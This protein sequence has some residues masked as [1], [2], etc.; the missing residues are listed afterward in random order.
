MK[1]KPNKRARRGKQ[2]TKSLEGAID[3]GATAHYIHERWRM[4]TGNPPET[5]TF[6]STNPLKRGIFQIEKKAYKQASFMEV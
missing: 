2:S 4:D 6:F 3:D 5:F 1:K